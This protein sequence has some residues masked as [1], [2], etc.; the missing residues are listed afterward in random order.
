METGSDSVSRV[1]YTNEE[2]LAR[3]TDWIMK[4]KKNQTKKG[5]RNPSRNWIKLKQK[6]AKIKKQ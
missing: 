4:R 6:E 5:R 3:E 1:F 2:E